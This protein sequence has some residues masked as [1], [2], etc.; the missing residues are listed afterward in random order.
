[1]REESG[2][3]ELRVARQHPEDGVK[4]GFEAVLLPDAHTQFVCHLVPERV[5]DDNDG[6]LVAVPH[7]RLHVTRRRR[8]SASAAT[9]ERHLSTLVYLLLP[10]IAQRVDELVGVALLDLLPQCLQR[11]R[12]LGH[13]RGIYEL[14]V[15]LVDAEPLAAIPL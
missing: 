10:R 8:T 14:P 11:L 13:A 3:P 2:H 5:R 12:V 15:E 1:M 7:Q 9:E 4:R 6:L